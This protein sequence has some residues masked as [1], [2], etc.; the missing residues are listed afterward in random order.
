MSAC[1]KRLLEVA[2]ISKRFGGLVAVRDLSLEMARGEV[3]GLIGPNGAGKTTA[4]N[5]LSG[6]LT[7]DQGEVRF[8]GHPLAG[9]KP[10]AICG[11]GLARTFQIVRPFPHLSVLDNVRVGA[12]ARRPQMAEAREKA[13]AVIDRV[14]LSAKTDHAAAGLTLAD[15]KRL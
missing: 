14:G 12:L 2:G 3:L 5:L 4:F 11:L 6:F 10:H 1:A 15:R 7:P 9:L 13:R 8:D